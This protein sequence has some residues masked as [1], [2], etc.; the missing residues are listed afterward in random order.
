LTAK[1]KSAGEN[2]SVFIL[3]DRLALN[4]AIDLLSSSVNLYD[5]VKL[6]HYVISCYKDIEVILNLKESGHASI[7]ELVEE[8]YQKAAHL[9]LWSVVR[10][11]AALSRKVVNSLTINVTDLLIRQ[12]YLTIGLGN[13][14]F[15]VY[16]PL[17][18]DA[19]VEIIYKR[20]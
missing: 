7:K 12:K 16:S 20:W 18:P 5:Q 3:E 6:L 10:Y 15:T 2:D 13:D 1:P 9:K 8:V 14:E 17:G 4:K 19:L 11:S